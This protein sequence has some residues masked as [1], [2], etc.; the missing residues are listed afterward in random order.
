MKTETA[1]TL[2]K[3]KRVE[4]KISEIVDD[5][6]SAF[7]VEELIWHPNQAHVSL[8]G[9]S[10]FESG[11]EDEIEEFVNAIINNNIKVW[12]GAAPVCWRCLSSD[13]DAA[14]ELCAL[15]AKR[16]AMRSYKRSPSARV[17]G[18]DLCEGLRWC[19]YEGCFNLPARDWCPVFSF[20]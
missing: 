14:G 17:C 3:A 20:K 11:D 2:A 13:V 4:T 19:T 16:P 15:C 5:P 8:E 10:V 9:T 6:F 7:D 12:W 18:H 1:K